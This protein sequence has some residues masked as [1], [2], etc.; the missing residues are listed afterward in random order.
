ML[1]KGLGNRGSSVITG[2]GLLAITGR[3]SISQIKLE[4]NENYVVH[5]R[6]VNQFAL[7]HI[8]NHHDVAM[9]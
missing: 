4:V 5:P 3:G 2:R 6:L 8:T 7:R 9:F 1:D